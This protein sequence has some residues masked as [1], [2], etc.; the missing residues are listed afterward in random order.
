[1][2]KKGY[3]AIAVAIALTGLAWGFANCTGS[4]RCIDGHGE[5]TS[6]PCP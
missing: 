5:F 2:S 4:E 1:M 6:R 3:L